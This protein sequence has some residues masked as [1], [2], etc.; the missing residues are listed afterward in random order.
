MITPSTNRQKPCATI[1]PMISDTMPSRI[2]T[3]QPIGST[4]GWKSRPRAP[5][6]APTM[7]SHSHDMS[8]VLPDQLLEP[9]PLLRELVIVEQ[10]GAMQL[11]EG[12]GQPRVLEALRIGPEPVGVDPQLL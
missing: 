11:L 4:P 5:T 2:V 10:P 12:S 6:I 8:G 1:P 3:I 7:I 9:R